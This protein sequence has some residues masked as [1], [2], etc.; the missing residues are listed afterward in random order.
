MK[1]HD[2]VIHHDET[3]LIFWDVFQPHRLIMEI[4]FQEIKIGDEL[5]QKRRIVMV[6]LVAQMDV[7]L[8]IHGVITP[9][10]PS[11]LKRGQS[12]ASP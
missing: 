6:E 10:S 4:F 1:G 7:L 5:V 9:P 12:G 11:Y 3:A 2:A 8:F